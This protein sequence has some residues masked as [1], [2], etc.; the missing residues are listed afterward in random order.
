MRTYFNETGID[1][2]VFW[3]F[4]YCRQYN[5]MATNKE[6]HLEELGKEAAFGDDVAF[7]DMVKEFPCIYNRGSPQF[8]DKNLKMNAWKRI[9]KFIS[10]ASGSGGDG[11]KQRQL[12][13]PK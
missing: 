10:K 9:S 11:G 12:F 7:M 3:D 4:R 8:K 6:K 2:D 1:W 13:S 5:K